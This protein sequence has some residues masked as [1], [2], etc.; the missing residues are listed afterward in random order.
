MAP[1]ENEPFMQRVREAALACSQIS[2]EDID[3]FYNNKKEIE[4]LVAESHD[5][6]KKYYC[7]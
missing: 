7:S 1:L 2:Y 4:K 5:I 6:A 3:M